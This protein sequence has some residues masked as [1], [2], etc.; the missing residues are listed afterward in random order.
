[1]QWRACIRQQ[2]AKTFFP[3]R[4][5]HRG[6][7]FA[8]EVE[9][10]EQEKDESI[11]VP[12]VRCVLDQ[13]EGGGAVRTDA[14]QL[15]VEIGLPGR[16]RRDRRSDRRVLTRPVETGAGQQPDRAPV[17]PGMHPVAVVFDFVQPLRPFG[18]RVH[19]FGELRF[20][21]AGER[22]RLGAPGSGE[23]SIHASIRSDRR[24][25]TSAAS[26]WSDFATRV[27]AGAIFSSVLWRVLI[28]RQT[29]G[30]E[31]P[32]S[33]PG[34]ASSNRR[35]FRMPL[36]CRSKVRGAAA[37]KGG[38]LPLA[39]GV[40]IVRYPIPQRTFKYVAM[41]QSGTDETCQKLTAPKDD[42]KATIL[43]SM[44]AA[45]RSVQNGARS[46]GAMEPAG[47]ARIQ[48]W[49]AAILT[50]DITGG[51][52][53]IELNEEEALGPLKRR[54]HGSCSGTSWCLLP[55]FGRRPHQRER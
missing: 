33:N 15:A 7:R 24:R 30:D 10:I 53:L 37:Q 47:P 32:E 54:R 2:P 31:D 22:C 50:A 12:R 4:N 39:L 29:F 11:A 20:D 44:R 3:L 14:A 35:G 27:P 34:V 55:R 18:R 49:L 45:R 52:R 51:L 36:S 48:G 9:E 6:D 46:G 13:A 40:S 43:C 25:Q 21:P 17:Q 28:N 5:R 1:M 42:F 41:V 19:Q 38:Y 8:I 16:E 23:R 26:S